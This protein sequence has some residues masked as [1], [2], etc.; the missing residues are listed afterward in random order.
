MYT[1]GFSLIDVVVGTAILLVVFVALLGVF[2]ASLA[3]TASAKARSG[4]TALASEQ[5]EFVRSLTYANTGT[6]GGIPAGTVPQTQTRTLNGI[7]YT[8]RTFIQY[9]DDSKDGL[10]TLDENGV[11][12]D[13]KKIKVTVSYSI[14][15][16]VQEVSLVS[17]RSPKGIETTEGGG[18]LQI[19][20]NN[21]V[22]DPVEGAQ[23][24]I[25]NPNTNPTVDV[26]VFSNTNGTVFLPGAA[27]S[28]GYKVTVSKSGYSTAQTY[29]QDAQNVS[30]NPGH[31]TVTEGVTTQSTFAIDVLSTLAV[32]TLEKIK[33]AFV[34]DSFSTSANFSSQNNTTVS[35]GSLVLSGN[36]SAGYISSGT[37]TATSTSPTYLAAWHSATATSTL[38]AGT[39][40]VYHIF[41]ESGGSYTLL[42]DTVLPG[43]TVGFTS[44]PIDLTGVATTTYPSLALGATLSTNDASSTPQI[45]SWRLSFSEGPI[46]IPN[47][48]FVA[49]GSKTIGID[50]TGA[51]ILK[52]TQNAVTGP[53]G[54]TTLLNLEWDSYNLTVSNYDVAEACQPLPLAVDPNTSPSINL[55]L[56]PQTSNALRLTVRDGASNALLS[57]VSAELVRGNYDT[58]VTTSSCGQAY[59]PALTKASDYTLTLS[60]SGYTTD[61]IS[62]VSV[63][64]MSTFSTT[65]DTL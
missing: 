27:T 15:N 38:P 57:G 17:N 4:A 55:F 22:G 7:D 1:R 3:L 48:S 43:N 18:T 29:D 32:A 41:Y 52:Y 10:G 63:D 44:T 16:R 50:G 14:N 34:E 30:P 40:A 33:D 5:M 20:T 12:T 36:A 53:D 21:A 2:R 46:P 19:Q 35:G 51:P 31:L 62:N 65:L 58:T 54:K 9:I 59:F 42:P 11:I 26:T 8:I 24:H 13:Y 28:T 23:V 47:V 39:S 56:E 45:H 37:A 6:V 49:T 60:K 25:Q 61:V 64:G